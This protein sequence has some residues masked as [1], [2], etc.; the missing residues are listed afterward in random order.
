MGAGCHTISRNVLLICHN[1]QTVILNELQNINSKF[2]KIGP[3][4]HT[5]TKISK[6]I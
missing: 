5:I 2:K 3:Y 6:N 4:N 1:C